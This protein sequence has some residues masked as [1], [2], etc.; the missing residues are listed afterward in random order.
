[1]QKHFIKNGGKSRIDQAEVEIADEKKDLEN[2]IDS[3]ITELEKS[4]RWGSQEVRKLVKDPKLTRLK[5]MVKDAY[6]LHMLDIER[7][8]EDT[9]E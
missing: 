9:E 1:V 8:P 6:K 4:T 2:K 3:A 7:L 5:E